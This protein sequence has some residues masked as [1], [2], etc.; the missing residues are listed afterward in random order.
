MRP[1]CPPHLI[2]ALGVGLAL[3]LAGCGLLDGGQRLS[4]MEVGDCLQFVETKETRD[5]AAVTGYQQ[6]DCALEG[7]FKVQ[8]AQINPAEGCPNDDYV[9]YGS[10]DHRVCLAPVLEVDKCYGPDEVAEWEELACD[11]EGVH[12]RIEKELS[13][14]DDGEC[15]EE[16]EHFV[17]PEPAPGK[18][19]C[20][21]A[22]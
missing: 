21:V 4:S 14:V 16:N 8:N 17:L 1:K 3:S 9:Y 19:Y 20:T 5:D 2:G 12:F 13:G 11:A 18:V 22:P 15:S 10:D 7:E 6:V